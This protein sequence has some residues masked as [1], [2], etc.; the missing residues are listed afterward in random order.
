[1]RWGRILAWVAA[2]L[3]A[4]PI[5][6]VLLV[7]GV[8]NTDPGRR[9][10]LSLVESVTGG[11]VRATGLSGRFP[12]RLRLETLEVADAEGVWLRGEAIR[13]DWAPTALI[14]G[15]LRVDSATLDSLDVRRLPVAAPTPDQPAPA[16]SDAPFRLPV[17]ADIERLAIARLELGPGVAAPASAALAVEAKLAGVSAED[18]SVDATLRRLDA[19]GQCRLRAARSGEGIAVNLAVTEPE[20]GLVQQVAALPALGDVTVTL[21]LDGPWQAAVLRLDA[22]A[23]ALRAEAAGTLDLAAV[24]GDLRV[25]ANAPAMTP[26]PGIAWD[27]IALDATLGGS[28][29]APR[30]EGSLR[31]EGLVTP[32]ARVASVALRF[33]A[34]PARARAEGEVVGL[35]LAGPE[36]GP[37]AAAPIRL[38]AELEL[39]AAERPLHFAVTHPS[40]DLSGD[41]TLG[42]TVTRIQA[43]LRLPEL[44]AL[45]P[46]DGVPLAGRVEVALGAE[47]D[48]TGTA[49]TARGTLA[50]RDGPAP[51]P[52]LLGAEAPFAFAARL[53]NGD[54][55]ISEASV[56]GARASFGIDGAVTSAGLDLNWRAALAELAV[57]APTMAGELR[58]TGTL[59]GPTD[60]FAAAATVEGTIAPPGL[61]A[62]RSPPAS[63][64]PACRGARGICA[65]KARSAA[66]P[67]T[68]PSRR[69]GGRMA[70]STSRST[71]GA[72]A[73][74]PSPARRPSMRP[75]RRATPGLRWRCRASRIS[76]RSPASRW[77]AG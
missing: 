58:A 57:L 76:L 56:T 74:P 68:S 55:A 64:P 5:V 18:F 67:S 39:D 7:L 59:R 15:R 37:F 8:A 45:A 49:L 46:L 9:G 66:G 25:Q 41:G 30:G 13:L 11:T 32:A 65:L 10:L 50:L 70:A 17:R 48:P 12:D 4:L 73:A 21:V 3:V 52:A 69:C 23:G 36:P 16:P 61:E 34:D 26:G 28:A 22:A 42:A 38:E 40:L 14:G 35:R 20:G 44:A 31:I 27:G 63:P 62:A 1:M 6:L 2:V 53:A 43:Q 19:E 71:P 24:A 75:T 47:I 33:N 72:G 77:P 60:N 54:I 51:L 29:T